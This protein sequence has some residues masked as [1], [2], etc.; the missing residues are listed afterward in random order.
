MAA[1]D[2]RIVATELQANTTAIKSVVDAL[3]T[4]VDAVNTQ[5]AAFVVN[6]IDGDLPTDLEV[7]AALADYDALVTTVGKPQNSMNDSLSVIRAAV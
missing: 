3:K 4:A 2:V 1:I 5:T 6:S 7:K